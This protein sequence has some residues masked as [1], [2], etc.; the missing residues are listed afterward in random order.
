[1]LEDKDRIFTNLYGLHDFRLAGARQRGEG[2]IPCSTQ[3]LPVSKEAIMMAHEGAILARRGTT[4]AS[5][6]RAAGAALIMLPMRRRRDAA[7]ACWMRRTASILIVAAAAAKDRAPCAKRRDAPLD[8]PRVAETDV[9]WTFHDARRT[10]NGDRYFTALPGGS[11]VARSRGP[12]GNVLW[13][14][15]SRAPDVLLCGAAAH[16]VAAL[17]V[18]SVGLVLLGGRSSQKDVSGSRARVRRA[19]SATG[20]RAASARTAWRRVMWSRSS[21]AVLL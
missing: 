17:H 4:P 21:A 19:W 10:D 8:C 14:D 16:N 12:Q 7:M 13:G 20:G 5:S 18:P 3:R 2:S 9:K 6:A 11:F 15:G 1:M